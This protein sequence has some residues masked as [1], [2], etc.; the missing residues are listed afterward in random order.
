MEFKQEQVEAALRGLLLSVSDDL[1]RD[2]DELWAMAARGALRHKFLPE[3]A[4]I[5]DDSGD[6]RPCNVRRNRTRGFV[7]PTPMIP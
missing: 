4:W 7:P 1:G 6:L 5:Y 2:L 3:T